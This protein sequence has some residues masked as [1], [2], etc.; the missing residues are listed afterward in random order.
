M[1]TADS[2]V[3]SRPDLEDLARRYDPQVLRE[4]LLDQEEAHV[5]GGFGG[6]GRGSGQ[7]GSPLSSSSR[8]Q[9]FPFGP[10]VYSLRPRC[11][12]RL[13]LLLAL[14]FC[15]YWSTVCYCGYA[16]HL[17]VSA[18][19]TQALPTFRTWLL[20]FT[21]LMGQ[22]ALEFMVAC[23]LTRPA[24]TRSRSFG[25]GVIGGLGE[26]GQTGFHVWDVSACLAGLGARTS[27]LLDVQCLPLMQRGSHLLFLLSS[28]T[29]AFAIG[30]FVFI[31]QLRL[32]LGLFCQR[33]N[34]SYDK[35]DLFFTDR[36]VH[37]MLECPPIAARSPSTA[38]ATMGDEGMGGAAGS[39]DHGLPFEEL[40]ELEEDDDGGLS[41]LVH[42]QDRPVPTNTIKV[43]NCAH[44]S[45]LSL[46][47]GVLARLYVPLN[48]QETQEFTVSATSFSRCFCEDVVQ[49]SVKFFFLMDCEM[50]L[51][52]L[53]SLLLSLAQAVG[54]CFYASSSALDLR[55]GGDGSTAEDGLLLQSVLQS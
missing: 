7:R 46:L 50:N 52:M 42:A 26:L 2:S 19:G 17:E 51:L 4:Y 8:N 33:D 35:P 18:L 34:F 21:M 54:S 23:V 38:T 22:A 5:H 9:R 49:C 48:C 55:L 44:L 45:D 16:F 10:E 3:S 31:V 15:A 25:A 11:F 39:G 14:N 30:L 29:F 13:R 43:A 6:H 32:V 47:H 1:M 40:D 53:L 28:G 24:R 37:G 36:D 27:I 20:S 41:D 12:V